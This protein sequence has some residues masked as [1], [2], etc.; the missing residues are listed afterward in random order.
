MIAWVAAPLSTIAC[1]R[2]AGDRARAERD[3]VAAG[4]LEQAG[5]ALAARRGSAEQGFDRLA[6]RVAGAE[7]DRS[8]D[9]RGQRVIGRDDQRRVARDREFVEPVALA[10][11]EDRRA[12]AKRDRGNEEQ[13]KNLRMFNFLL[14]PFRAKQEGTQ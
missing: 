5:F 8:G 10:A 13:G 4:A 1:R 9:R 11:A 2:I 7:A 14:G 6:L 3:A 12:A